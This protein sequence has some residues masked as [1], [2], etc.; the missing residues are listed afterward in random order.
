MVYH[1]PGLTSG[2]STTSGRR[3]STSPYSAVD[4]LFGDIFPYQGLKICL[5]P[6]NRL[7]IKIARKCS[8]IPL[9]PC[10]MSRD[11]RREA[12]GPETAQPT[13]I[14]VLGCRR[15]PCLQTVKSGPTRCVLKNRPDLPQK[16]A[17]TL[18]RPRI[19]RGSALAGQI[20]RQGAASRR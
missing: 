1:G 4:R 9:K 13:R 16:T 3:T 18:S 11:R 14:T 12:C 7:T 15:W 6:E 10:I 8:K 19:R 5:F 2:R 20:W 17:A